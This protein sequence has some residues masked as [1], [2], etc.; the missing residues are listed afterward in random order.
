LSPRTEL[1]S[2]LTALSIPSLMRVFLS[3]MY[4]L[5]LSTLQNYNKFIFSINC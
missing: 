1:P 5:G 3:L 2:L 4:A